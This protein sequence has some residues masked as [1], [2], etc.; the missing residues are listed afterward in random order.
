[1]AVDEK[2]DVS[3]LACPMPIIKTKK[4]IAAM[5][6][7]ET[8]EIIATDAGS[9]ADL[10]AWA[11]STG[12]H[13]VGL[14]EEGAVLKHYMRKCD[15]TMTN[16]MHFKS[17]ITN[18]ELLKISPKPNIIDVRESIEY[19]FGHIKGAVS[20]PLGE[21]ALK[22]ASFDQEQTYYL[23]CRSGTRSDLACKLMVDHGFKH[24]VNVLPGMQS[25]T[26]DLEKNI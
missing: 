20:M 25:I 3:G 14:I 8:L 15:V 21:L 19:D 1:M 18:E 2:L 22:L 12:H 17:T 13:Y 9:K 11:Q 10:P 7:G 5:K 6:I 23:I 16:E 24:I 26:T 4:A